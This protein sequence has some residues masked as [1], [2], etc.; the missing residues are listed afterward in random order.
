MRIWAWKSKTLVNI[1]STYCNK[2][3][4]RTYMFSFFSSSKSVPQWANFFN[5]KEYTRFINAVDSYF[6]I[7]NLRY[8]ID[9]GVLKTDEE[10]F[11]V[12]ALG[13]TNIAQTCKLEH[14]QDWSDLVTHHFDGMMAAKVFDREFQSKKHNFEYAKGFL[15]V[16][17]YHRHHFDTVGIEN[18]IYEPF[19]DDI[20][21]V[22]V[23]DLPHTV[24]NVKPEDAKL[25]PKSIDELLKYGSDSVKQRYPVQASHERFN[26]F[27]I[28]FISDNHLFATNAVLD[29]EGMHKYTGSKGALVGIPHRHAVLIYPIETLEVVQAINTLIPIIAGMYSEGPGSISKNIFWYRDGQFTNLPYEL[30]KAKLRFSPPDSFVEMIQGIN[31]PAKK[32]S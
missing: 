9:D 2:T 32:Q 25:W 31:S 22:L 19:A 26:E 21:K 30:T 4:K 11:G 24:S 27:D 6:K 28:W 15:A 14:D 10:V 3:Q 8:T 17:L 29:Q 20:M 12:D 1:A 16:R 18:I 23:Y 5:A 7:K 13:L